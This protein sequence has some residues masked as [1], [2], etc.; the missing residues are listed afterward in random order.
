[1]KIAVTGANGHVGGNLCR[2]LLHQG[3][4]VKALVHKDDSSIRDLN[5]ERIKGDLAD[6]SS[7]VILCKDAEVVFH[8]AALI[9][10]GGNRKALELTNVT[11]TRNLID[12][13][14]KSKVSRLVHFSS[15]HALEH[16]PVDQPMDETRPLV[17][18]ALMMYEST[19]AK[20]DLLVQESIAKGLDAVILN[21]TAILGPYD[22]KPSLVGQVLLR[23]YKG[24]LPALVPGGYDWVDVRDIVQAAISA[25][26]K[27]KTGE[28]YILSGQWL[29]VGELARSLEEVTNKEI[30]KLTI[31]TSVARI[32]VP[33]I[34]I[35]SMISGQHPL[36][37]FQSLDVLMN[38]NR[39][40][41]NDKA[42]RELDFSPRPIKETLADSI[43]W[44]RMNGYLN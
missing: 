15:I 28:R 20:G 18:K 32:G 16:N 2:A 26:T 4:Q 7:L 36:Y 13:M 3:H 9:S 30:V 17:T 27:G 22:Y 5:V 44:F 10:V 43:E 34:K 12:A 37:T 25:M 31:P 8:L 40:I 6:P 24:T 35:Y 29:S 41:I 33:F 23:L 1:M 14:L 11:G 21:P 38:G 19:K 42:R 39:M